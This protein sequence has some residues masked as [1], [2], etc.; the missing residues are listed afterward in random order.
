MTP[1][2]VYGPPCVVPNC[3]RKSVEKGFCEFHRPK[4]PS[5]V[6]QRRQ[7]LARVQ[8]AQEAATGGIEE[9]AKGPVDA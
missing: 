4:K 2:R 1:L 7:I 9:V 8:Q 3:Q 5:L 6:A